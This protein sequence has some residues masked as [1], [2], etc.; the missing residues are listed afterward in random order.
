MNY[1][2]FNDV[3][4]YIP[5]DQNTIQNSQY[6]DNELSKSILDF[7]NKHNSNKYVVSLSG[8]VD[9]MVL[10]SILHAKNIKVIA[11]HINYNNRIESKKEEE[12][13]KTW[14]ECNKIKLY[15]KSI[16]DIHRCSSNRTEYENTT[17]NIR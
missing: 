13:L 5:N 3:L 12:F 17:K 15:V 4:Q 8:G 1:N 7:H 9:S 10:I 11:V 16:D 2:I 6:K 14:C